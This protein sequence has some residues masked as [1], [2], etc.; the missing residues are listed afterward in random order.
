MTIINKSDKTILEAGNLND[1]PSLNVMQRI[2]SDGRIKQN[3][4]KDFNN[5]IRKLITLY[6]SVLTGI[7][8]Q[9]FIQKYVEYPFSVT[10]FG[11]AQLEYFLSLKK[12]FVHLDATGSII[13]QP[14]S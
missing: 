10:F 9:G 11:E 13:A 1:V 7:H 5:Y 8:I 12:G 2:M 14:Q 6:N 4:D 3:L